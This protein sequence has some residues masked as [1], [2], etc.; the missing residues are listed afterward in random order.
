MF[1]L[2][3][4]S[5]HG[6]KK[7]KYFEYRAKEREERINVCLCTL[8]LGRVVLNALQDGPDG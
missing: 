4:W 1:G 6:E 8:I 5:R 3:I 7:M 2:V